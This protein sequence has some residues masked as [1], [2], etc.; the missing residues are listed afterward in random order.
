MEQKISKEDR[1]TAMHF[2]QY[3]GK[4]VA[5][6][7]GRVGAAGDTIEKLDQEIEKKNLKGFAYHHVPPINVSLAV[8]AWEI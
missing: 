2:A 1:E 5:V 8:S 4:W 7:N 6:V 3:A